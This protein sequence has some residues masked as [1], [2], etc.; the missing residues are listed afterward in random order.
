MKVLELEDSGSRFRLAQCAVG[1]VGCL[2]VAYAV[3]TPG[4]LGDKGLWTHWND[5]DQDQTEQAYAPSE[6][7]IWNALEAERVF[8]VL[9][10]FMAVSSGALC[11]VFS[12]C[13]TSK[14]VFSYSNTRSLLM[15][16][17]AL[18][19]TTL[20][21]LTLGPTGFFFLL[22]WSLFTYQHWSEISD[23]VGR[24]G[25]SYWLGALG[26]VLLLVVLPV[27][28]LVEQ[29]VVPDILPGL[30]KSL[31]LI[32]NNNHLPYAFRSISER[33]PHCANEGTNRDLRRIVSVP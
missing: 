6:G 20:L 15:A 2:F 21:L 12:F 31:R 28:F 10:F 19:P 33:H 7:L 9:S 30:R 26:W 22:S 1:L 16:G 5:T 25:F 32:Q 23:D 13:W 27:V 18:Y 17:Q 24:L 11:F 4:W 3:W 14:T 8:G 29:S